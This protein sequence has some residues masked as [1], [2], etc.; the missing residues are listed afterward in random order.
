MSLPLMA[1]LVVLAHFAWMAFIVGGQVLILAGALRRWNWVRNP[2]FR[3][4]HLMAISLVA[5]E[6]SV[7]MLC[8]L[9][10]WE[11]G[12]RMAGGQSPEEGSFVG[13]LAHRLLFFD[14]PETVFTTAYVLFTLLVIATLV[15]I[16]PRRPKAR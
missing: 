1:D 10:Q 13:R 5:L 11:F 7:G 15:A 2:G 6:S 16:P 3:Y 14:L 12:L 4:A 9:T 8:P